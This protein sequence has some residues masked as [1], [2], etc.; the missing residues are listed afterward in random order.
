[1]CLSKEGKSDK[2]PGKDPTV[3]RKEPG[4]DPTVERSG[5]DGQKGS[6]VEKA[7][8]TTQ[9][10]REIL[11]TPLSLSFLL[12]INKASVHRVGRHGGRIDTCRVGLLDE[13]TILPLGL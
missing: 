8:A 2:E 11:R 13:M 4:K 12:L 3:E 7:I 9:K 10:R 1:M 5:S 6:S